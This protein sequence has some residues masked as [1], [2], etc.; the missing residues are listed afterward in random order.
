MSDL[1]ACLSWSRTAISSQPF[2]LPGQKGW[3]IAHQLLVDHF[4]LSLNHI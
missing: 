2:A 3:S 1:L 4:L